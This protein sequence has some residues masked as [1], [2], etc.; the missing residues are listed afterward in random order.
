MKLQFPAKGYPSDLVQ[1]EMSEVKFSGDW[2]KN[3]TKKKSKGVRLVI[4]FH[5]LLKDFGNIIH[6]NLHLLYM[7]QEVQR[8]FTPEPMITS[9]SARKLTSYLL[10]TKLYPLERTVGSKYLQNKS[11]I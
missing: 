7:D 4:T 5:S 11:P 2:N 1:K 6:K 3:Q 10:R 9:R 8:V